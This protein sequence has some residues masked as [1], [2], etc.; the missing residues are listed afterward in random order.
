L[1]SSEYHLAKIRRASSGFVIFA[2]MCLR[3]ILEHLVSDFDKA[4]QES[5][6]RP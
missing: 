2:P 1:V 4:T 6:K 3:P 5:A